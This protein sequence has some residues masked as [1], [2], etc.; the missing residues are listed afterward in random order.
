MRR[1]LGRRKGVHCAAALAL[2]LPA[3]L[4]LAAA[5]AAT[6]ALAAA[7]AAT[8][9]APTVHLLALYLLPKVQNFRG[10]DQKM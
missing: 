1:D 2:V 4:A 5:A 8:V 3:A 7:A 6:V 9:A 10:L